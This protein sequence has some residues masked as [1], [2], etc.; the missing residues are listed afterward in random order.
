M[1]GL[2]LRKR[3]F[4]GPRI[5]E[6]ADKKTANNEGRLYSETYLFEFG[7]KKV[8]FGLYAGRFIRC[9]VG[10]LRLK[11]FFFCFF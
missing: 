8:H 4:F 7:P 9:P 5:S 3:Q 11:C 2:V 1:E 10:Y 6:T